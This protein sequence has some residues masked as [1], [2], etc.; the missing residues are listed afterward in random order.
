MSRRILVIDDAADIRE[1]A[2]MSLARVGG[3]D[4][5]TANGGDEGLRAA[6]EGRPDAI[7]LDVMMP[8]LDGPETLQRL[9]AET[10][11]AGIPVIL[12]TAKVQAADRQRFAALGV[13]G[14][15]AKPFDPVRLPLDVAAMLGWAS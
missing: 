9:R 5:V 8:G 10:A 14:V 1:I 6:R 15:V 7:L 4:V 12:L 13:A 11:L 2:E 3:F